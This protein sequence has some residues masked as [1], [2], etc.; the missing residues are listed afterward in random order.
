MEQSSLSKT[1]NTPKTSSRINISYYKPLALLRK[2]IICLALVAIILAFLPY[3]NY[4]PENYS[5]YYLIFY[6]VVLIALSILS[7]LFTQWSIEYYSFIAFQKV[8]NSFN[9][10]KK[11]YYSSYLIRSKM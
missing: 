3:S 2:D 11:L 1:S 5:Q 10:F 9:W 6:I 7:F 8:H 4:I